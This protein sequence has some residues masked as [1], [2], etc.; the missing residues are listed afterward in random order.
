[1]Y[2]G[3]SIGVVIPAYNVERSIRK[4]VEGIPSWVDRIIVVDD[5]S[6]DGTLS[7]ARRSP[8]SAR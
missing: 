1:M 2:R 7:E 8:P 3:R 5:A 4:V 6:R